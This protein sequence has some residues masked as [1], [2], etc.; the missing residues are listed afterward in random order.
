MSNLFA[1][2]PFWSALGCTVVTIPISSSG[3]L[4]FACST[5]W[6]AANELRN[7]VVPKH[8]AD[9]QK[10]SS[11]W[12]KYVKEKLASPGFFPFL[13]FIIYLWSGA[14]AILAHKI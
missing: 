14:H 1:S 13:Q 3:A 4:L 7:Q 6:T 11:A 5:L 2:P 8:T 9:G 10:S 12:Q